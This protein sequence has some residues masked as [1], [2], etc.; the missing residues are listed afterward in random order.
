MQTRMREQTRGIRGTLPR[1]NFKFKRSE[2]AINA[3]K[4]ANSS[5]NL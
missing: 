5:I 4:T 3:A 1:E 2:M